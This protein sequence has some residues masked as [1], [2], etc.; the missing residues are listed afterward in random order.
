MEEDAGLLA[1]Y[2]AESGVIATPVKIGQMVY[3]ALPR[4]FF[5]ESIVYA[6]E[7]KGL[8]VDE[9]GKY[10]AFDEYGEHY[11]VGEESCRFTKEEAEQ[12][13]RNFEAEYAKENDDEC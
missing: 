5:D 1:E 7:V 12:D 9:K 10:I 8:G 3:A 13:L 2:L 11:I 6:W 4:V